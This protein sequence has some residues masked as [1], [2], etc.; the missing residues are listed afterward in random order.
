MKLFGKPA[1][2][3]ALLCGMCMIAAAAAADV[4]VTMKTDEWTLEPGT[5]CL[6]P[7]T[8]STDGEDLPGASL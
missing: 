1:A 7:G 4:S 6:F 8:V 2:L 3:P 5:V